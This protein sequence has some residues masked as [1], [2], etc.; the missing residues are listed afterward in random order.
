MASNDVDAL[1][2]DLLGDEEE[3]A[4]AQEQQKPINSEQVGSYHRNS[5]QRPF[6][7]CFSRGVCKSRTNT[8]QG[9]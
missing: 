5:N 3:E 6:A 8:C 2:L 1:L 7:A 9:F 4:T